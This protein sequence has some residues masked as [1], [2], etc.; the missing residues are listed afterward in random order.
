MGG[1]ARSSR[2]DVGVAEIAALEQR[3]FAR[4][5]PP[6][7]ATTRQDGPRSEKRLAPKSTG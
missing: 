5:R 3:F 6:R 1:A 4:R 7:D 2:R